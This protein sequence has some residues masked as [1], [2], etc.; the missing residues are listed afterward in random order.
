MSPCPSAPHCGA[1]TGFPG[2]GVPLGANDTDPDAPKGGGGGSS[3]ALATDSGDALGSGGR[4][5]GP[6]S[7]VVGEAMGGRMP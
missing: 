2:C 4:I 7:D 3:G 1:G 5:A 6:V